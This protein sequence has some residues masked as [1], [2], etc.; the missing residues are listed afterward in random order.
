MGKLTNW[1][2]EGQRPTGLHDHRNLLK[3]R[4]DRRKREELL[5]VVASDQAMVEWMAPWR[6]GQRASSIK[7]R[8]M[9][10]AS[11]GADCG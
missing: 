10:N 3:S 6:G 5:G 11:N 7:F 8:V 1:R 2:Q 9:I 4:V